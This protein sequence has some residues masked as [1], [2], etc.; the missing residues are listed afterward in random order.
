M[1]ITE[2]LLLDNYGAIT[3]VG[4]LISYINKKAVFWVYKNY[5]GT[6][7]DRDSAESIDLCYDRFGTIEIDEDNNGHNAL[8]TISDDEAKLWGDKC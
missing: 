7:C 5:E 6:T 4:N 3:L 1:I 8:R 2:K